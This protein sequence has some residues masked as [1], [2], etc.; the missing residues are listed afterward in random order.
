MRIVDKAGKV[1]RE[2][3]FIDQKRRGDCSVRGDL[4]PILRADID[5]TAW[6]RFFKIVA[7]SRR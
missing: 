5:L 2:V 3:E 7:T 6:H 4:D 1:M